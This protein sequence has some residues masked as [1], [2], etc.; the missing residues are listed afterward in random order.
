M[1]KQEII[2]YWHNAATGLDELVVW[3]KAVYFLGPKV[4][5]GVRKHKTCLVKLSIPACTAIMVGDEGHRYNGRGAVK[6]R[7][8]KVRVLSLHTCTG[9]PL[10]PNKEVVA[11]HNPKVVYKV[12][13]IVKPKGAQF[14]ARQ[15][16]SC[17]PGIHFFFN[18]SHAARYA[19]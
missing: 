1:E 5:F 10:D 17:A 9:T 14:S 12:G 2:E 19:L 13:Q 8:E 15:R 7:A 16:Q 18:R 11:R 3:K 4:A 6:C